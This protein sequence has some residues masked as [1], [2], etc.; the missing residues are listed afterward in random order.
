M[1]LKGLGNL[2]STSLKQFAS[3]WDWFI[4]TSKAA[5]S[6]RSQQLGMT[7]SSLIRQAVISESSPG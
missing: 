3:P 2:R 6:F 4:N 7:C 1:G 5:L